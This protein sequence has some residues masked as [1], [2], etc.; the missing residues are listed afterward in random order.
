MSKLLQVVKEKKNHSIE[1]GKS[2]K[3]ENT[4]EI[5]DLLDREENKGIGSQLKF[6]PTCEAQNFDDINRRKGTKPCLYL[7]NTRIQKTANSCRRLKK[8]PKKAQAKAAI[9]ISG[10]EK[11]LEKD[12]KS[13]DKNIMVDT[14]STLEEIENKCLFSIA[15]LEQRKTKYT[16]ELM[17]TLLQ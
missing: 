5:I 16:N 14:S 11:E 9:E 6:E 15:S 4:K 12:C 2:S 10:K 3:F 17:E 8:K 1:K 7:A 13:H